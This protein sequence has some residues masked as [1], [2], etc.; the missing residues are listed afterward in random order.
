MKNVRKMNLCDSVSIRAHMR[1]T[2]ISLHCIM[3][4]L[5]F[6]EHF[7]IRN[8]SKAR[9]INCVNSFEENFY[10]SSFFYS[11]FIRCMSQLADFSNHFLFNFSMFFCCSWYFG[12]VLGVNIPIEAPKIPVPDEILFFF[13]PILQFLWRW[14]RS[15][16][17]YPCAFDCM[18]FINYHHYSEI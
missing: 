16:V 17:L 5:F 7:W 6:P 10:F 2:V 13:S 3:V 8:W 14:H 4:D 1:L 9:I 11:F 18:S 15:N 12:S